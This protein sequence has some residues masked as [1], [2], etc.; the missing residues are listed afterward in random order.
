MGE[1]A[2][3][4]ERVAERGRETGR[5]RIRTHGEVE[6]RKA[7][8]HDVLELDYYLRVDGRLDRV[9]ARLDQPTRF[10]PEQRGVHARRAADRA[11]VTDFECPR[12]LRFEVGV[13]HDPEAVHEQVGKPLGEG[14]GTKPATGRGAP[15]AGP[16]Q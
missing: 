1:L 6:S 10:G 5:E 3:V 4:E 7:S 2:G 12:F 13:G 14:G 15:D 9:D 11:R 8:A 16:G